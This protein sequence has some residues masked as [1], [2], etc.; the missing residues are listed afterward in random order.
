MN[1]QKNVKFN[2]LKGYYADASAINMLGF[3]MIKG[4]PKDVLNS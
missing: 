3:K 4:S 2:E 1:E